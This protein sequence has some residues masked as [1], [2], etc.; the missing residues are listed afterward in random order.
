MVGL[1]M[2]VDLD[3]VLNQ[4]PVEEDQ[5]SHLTATMVRL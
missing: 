3:T 1:L 2:I 5:N 4:E